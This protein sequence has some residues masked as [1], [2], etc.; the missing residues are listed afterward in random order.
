MSAPDIVGAAPAPSS[1]S[2]DSPPGRR[3]T[4]RPLMMRLHFYAGILVAP[5][6]LIAAVSGGLYAVAPALEQVVYRDYLH[7]TYSG[8]AFP[9]ADQIRAAQQTRPDLTV[10]AVRPAPDPGDTTRVL[11]TDPTLGESERLA[12]FVDPSTARPVGELTVYGSSSALPMRTWISQLHRHLH[13]GEPGRIYSELASS[14][15]WVIALGGLYLW[16]DRYRKARTRDAA[17]ARL[18][19]VDRSTRGRARTLGWHG[20]VGAW[21]AVGLV[22]LSATGLTWSKYAGENVGDLRTALSWTTPSLDKT[23]DDAAPSG[24]SH[25]GH[26]AAATAG[27]ADTSILDSNVDR[28]DSVLAIAADN[29][30][31]RAVEASIPAAA[32]TAFTV[33][34]TRQPWALATD[35]VSVDGA[36]GH[37]VDVL[38]FSTYPL[39]AK[40]T[41]W[42]IA[43]HMGLLFGLLNQIALAA[44]AVALVTVIVRGYVLWWRRRPTRGSDRA[45]GRP[46]LRGALRQLHPA[47]GVAIVAAAALVGWFVPLLGLS[48]LAFLAVD[49]GFGLVARA[50][51]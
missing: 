9:V 8:P 47:V 7:V 48:L 32:S 23:I 42:G 37:L 38:P 30:V 5:L 15:M 43:L 51:A 22:F 18:L 36:T 10:A 33:A 50:R 44:L 26:G 31:D 49:A 1:T 39:A 21:I 35:S 28:V 40:L 24:G 34:E 45:V 41:S 4:L 27:T 25:E 17:S 16:W 2:T 13:L 12:V 29:G 3:Y 6:I 46:P 19:T 14:W 11:F 20:A